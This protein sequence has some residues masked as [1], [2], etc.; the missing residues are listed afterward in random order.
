MRDPASDSRHSAHSPAKSL[1]KALA[2]LDAVAASP[3]PLTTA[4]VATIARIARPTAYRLVHTL[5]AEGYLTSDSRGRLQPGFAVI[6][7][8]AKVL[9]GDRIRAE[10]LPQLH[11]LAAAT[12]ERANLGGIFKGRVLY[13][14]GS[15]K[16][17]LPVLH[18]RFGR[19]VPV[20]CSAMGKAILSELSE[21]EVRA[22]LRDRPLPAFTE[23]T[24]TDIDRLLKALDE[25]RLQGYALNNA[26]YIA[27]WYSVAVPVRPK[28]GRTEV[29]VNLTG[30]SL[31]TL[32][33]HL[34]KLRETAEVIAH[35]I[36]FVE[37]SR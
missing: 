34:D 5:E 28:G 22:I 25:V 17:N 31:Q 27:G 29:A 23:T 30:H 20:H 36:E 1:Q 37:P 10:A 24:I 33:N 32:L 8:A 2:I 4:E 14:A 18:A 13:M 6:S 9:D 15:D 16:P 12:G 21:S 35:K 3:H 11:V 7:L 26:E 19:I